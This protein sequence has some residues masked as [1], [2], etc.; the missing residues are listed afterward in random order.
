[1]KKFN[2]KRQLFCSI[3]TNRCCTAVGTMV[4]ADTFIF[5]DT[6]LNPSMDALT[7][8]WC[9]KI[10][11]SKD[12]HIY[13]SLFQSWKKCFC[14][15]W[16]LEGSMVAITFQLLNR[17][18]EKTLR[19]FS[20]SLR[21]ESGNSIEEKLLK[22]GTKDLIREVAAQGT[23]YTLAFLTQVSLTGVFFT[24]VTSR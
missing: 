8:E 22:N 3:L 4:D 7:Q 15:F 5:Y 11:R 17:V 12:I 10:G 19:G 6:D 23:D 21:L 18:I 20:V 2:R 14:S 1:M 13:R 9:D 24:F 16:S